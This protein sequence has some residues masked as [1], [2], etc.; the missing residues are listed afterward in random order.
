MQCVLITGG[1]GLLG[2]NLALDYA[3]G[4]RVH[5]TFYKNPVKLNAVEFHLVNLVDESKVRKLLNIK[6]NLIIHS[7]GLADVDYCQS[8]PR[9]AFK[10][11]VI[12]SRIIAQLAKRLGAKLVHISTDM[13]FDGKA[14]SPYKEIDDPS[15]VNVYGITK[16]AAER[17][18]LSTTKN[19][20]II[21]TAFYGWNV[22]SKLSLGEFFLKKMIRRQIV[23]GFKDILSNL[24]LTNDLGKTILELV[25]KNAKG[26]YHVGSHKPITKYRLAE[27]I[28][29][30]FK[31]PEAKINAVSSLNTKPKVI[32][33]KFRGLNVVKTEALLGH[34]LPIARQGVEH[35][36]KKYQDGFVVKLKPKFDP[37]LKKLRHHIIKTA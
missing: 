20:L 8:N 21:R 26:I 35:F 16:L 14:K 4:Y 24:C 1:S 10:V 22:R 33:P 23:P 31:F 37:W 27:L 34:S 3:R 25:K 19:S 6:P 5:A 12:G 28:S 18:V 11:H 2:S 30:V 13:V 32:R 15:P 17:E 29:T 7:A 36:Y 9:E